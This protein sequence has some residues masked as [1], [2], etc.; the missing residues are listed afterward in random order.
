MRSTLH[1]GLLFLALPLLAQSNTGELR[2]RVTGPDGIPLKAAIELSS[3]AIRFHRS[4]SSDDSGAV[5]TRN[6]PFGRYR[7]RVECE[8]FSP[9]DGLLE[10]HSAL[11]T[12]Y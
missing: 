11:P 5:V 7:L 12:E 4:F 6:L 1:F 8:S 2:L 10:I 9:F 3:D